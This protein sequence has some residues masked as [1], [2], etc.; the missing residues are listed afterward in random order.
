MTDD[1]TF[2]SVDHVLSIHRRMIEEFGG[3]ATVRDHG[4]LESAV[5]M[6]AARFG[7][8][9]L[10]DGIPAMAAA[11]FFHLCKNHPFMDGNKRTALASAEMFV[12]LNEMH[13]A[14]T[15]EELQEL[16]LGVAEGRISKDETITFFRQHVLPGDS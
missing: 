12:L 13:L 5:M 6:P 11:H 10:H 8:E 4:L 9:F 7:G 1:P 15:N 14:A 16:T 3:D 2:L